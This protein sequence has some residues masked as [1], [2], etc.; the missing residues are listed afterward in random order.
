ME[1]VFDTSKN[2]KVAMMTLGCKTN[3]VE[4][5][6][7]LGALSDA[8]CEVVDFDEAAD[9]YIINTCTV[10]HVSDRK[11]RQM[12]RRAKK[13]S[14]DAKVVCMGCYSQLN[15]DEVRKMG[16][17][18]VLGNSNKNIVIDYILSGGE[19]MTDAGGGLMSGAVNSSPFVVI[20]SLKSFENIPE[21][22]ASRHTRAFVKIQDGCDRYCTYCIIPYARGGL[23]SRELGSIVSEVR[24]LVCSGYSEF[25]L[26]GIHIA[27]YGKEGGFQKNL[28]DVVEALNSIEGVRRIRLGSLE[29]A[30]IDERTLARMAACDKLCDHFHLSLQSGSDKVL[31]LMNR[32]YSAEDFLKAVEMLR[33]VYDNPSITTDIIVGFP[34][35]GD[36]EFAETVEMA[37]KARFSDIHI[38]PY[39]ERSGTPAVKFS[40]K[41]DENIKKQR[42]HIL[43]TVAKKLREDYCASSANSVVLIEE[44]SDGVASG[45]TSNYIYRSF[46]A[47]GRSVG[48][49]A[50]CSV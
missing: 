10:T 40:E 8:G 50:D 33:G 41:V 23:R 24:R 25:V 34:G 35:E 4:S 37:K 39:S 14:K 22:T 38:F 17:D 47:N 19:V 21:Y 45:Y 18:L 5:E 42:L 48:D 29:P 6:A 36:A 44:I 46:A 30:F 16:V 2:I 26:T 11:S 9:F 15:H 31:K 7:I 27:S 32:R 28:L 20:D 3:I 49:Y 12:I 43:E 1:N 13:M